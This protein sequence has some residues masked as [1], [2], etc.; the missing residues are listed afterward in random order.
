MMLAR[1]SF[2]IISS[3]ESEDVKGIKRYSSSY[4]AAMNA[5]IRQIPRVSLMSEVGET[6]SLIWRAAMGVVE[7]AGSWVDKLI[8]MCVNR[9]MG[10]CM[11]DSSMFEGENQILALLFISVRRHGCV[12]MILYKTD[13]DRQLIRTHGSL[14]LS[15]IGRWLGAQAE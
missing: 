13:R 14:P 15:V 6:S 1:W 3:D 10:W 11:M 9:L 4:I 2:H 5:P 7:I 12:A 8:S